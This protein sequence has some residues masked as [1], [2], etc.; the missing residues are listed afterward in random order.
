MNHETVGSLLAVIANSLN[1][2]LRIMMFADKKAWGPDEFEQLRLLEEA[3]D[4]AK[5]DFQELP[6]LVNGRFYYENDRI[7]ESLEDLRILCTRFELHTQNFK[8]WVRNGGV[9]PIEAAWAR[10]TVTLRTELHRAQCRA[11]RRVHSAQQVDNLSGSP[12]RC[13]GALQVYRVQQQQHR[14]RSDPRKREDEERL[15]CARAGRFERF[16]NQNVAFVCD[17]C[18]GF[19]IWDDLRAMPTTRIRMNPSPSSPPQPPLPLHLGAGNAPASAQGG[20]S[21]SSNSDPGDL[22]SSSSSST[23]QAR[24]I[25]MT[26]GETKTVVFAPVAV[27]NHVP[28]DVGDWRSRVLCPYCDEYYYEE[29]GDDD[30]ERVR[31][32]QDGSGFDGIGAFQA[33]LEWSHAPIVPSISA[34]SCQIM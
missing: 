3:L 34:S 24:G 7:E 21:S 12:S 8:D 27:A 11:A 16:G 17:F 2:G 1:D 10:E 14:Q 33:H 9:P 4:E 26:N 23:W 18:D 32:V 13:L 29:Q 28:P 6:D 15:A 25:A 30:M 31:Y 20:S 22:E 19:L 5:K